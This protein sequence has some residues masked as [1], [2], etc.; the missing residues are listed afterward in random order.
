MDSIFLRYTVVAAC[1]RRR[2]RCTG[3]R[4]AGARQTPGDLDGRLIP[5]RRPGD[6]GR[7]RPH[8]HA[9]RR[10]RPCRLETRRQE[11]RGND[12]RARPRPGIPGRSTCSPTAVPPA[13]SESSGSTRSRRTRSPSAWPI[14]TCRAA[15]VQGRERLEAYPHGIQAS[16]PRPKEMNA[17][18]D[19]GLHR[20]VI[21]RKR[22]HRS[23]VCP[24]LRGE[25]VN[26]PSDH[27]AESRRR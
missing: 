24:D 17:P 11:L 21:C 8:D 22:V 10:G 26:R 13:A 9:D 16:G 3:A 4:E 27:A 12:R 14:P 23:F 25:S 1:L 18:G 6:A 15:R 20:S 19:A 7:G 5:P 2:G